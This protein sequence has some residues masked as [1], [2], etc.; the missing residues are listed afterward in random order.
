MKRQKGKSHTLLKEWRA[1]GISYRIG[2]EETGIPRSVLHGFLHGDKRLGQRSNPEPVIRA[3][4]ESKKPSLEVTSEPLAKKL[5]GLGLTV[6]DAAAGMH[7]LKISKGDLYRYLALGKWPNQATVDVF[8]KWLEKERDRRKIKMLTKVTLHEEEL[9]HYGLKRDP[10]TNEMESEED[11]LDTKDLQRA[12]KKILTAI[13]K[14]GWVAVTGDVGSGKTTLIK[15]IKGRVAGKKEI[16]LIEPRTIEKQYLGAGH[17]CLAILRD[18]GMEHIASRQDLESKARLVAYSLQEAARDGKK[19]VILIDEA[20]LL[21]NDALLALKRLYE[22]ES[23]FK[24]LLSLILVGQISLAQRLRSDPGLREVSQRVDLYELGGLNGAIGAYLEYKLSRA[25]LNGSA[26]DLF[27]KDA[28]KAIS[29]RAD[30]PLLVNNLAAAAL[31]KAFDYDEK[32]VSAE[33]VKA[34]QGSF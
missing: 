8:R 10:F 22:F 13:A 7:P 25:G 5:F 24:K 23:G 9:K 30:T 28:L 27:D 16:V 15:K 29:A 6:K 19:V 34:V 4:L 32:R 1:L 12:E 17:L 3:Y 11:I 20:H 26:A 33:I 31:L 14:N 2:A 21:R 18:L